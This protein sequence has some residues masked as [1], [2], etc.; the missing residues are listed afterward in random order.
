MKCCENDKKLT[1][2]LPLFTKTGT[3]PVEYT[4]NGIKYF[5]IPGNTDIRS[6]R[7]KDGTVARTV[8]TCILPGGLELRAENTEYSDFPV[9]E[10]VAFIKN[11]CAGRSAVITDFRICASLPADGDFMFCHGNGET[12][13]P[14]GYGWE[15]VPLDRGFEISPKPDGTSC[16]LA[17]PYFRLIGE[18]NG[19]NIAVGWS[20]T[21]S[22]SVEKEQ[23]QIIISASQ[24]RFRVSLEPGETVRTPLVVIQAFDG[25]ESRGRNL[26]RSFYLEHYLPRRKGRPLGPMLVLHTPG[27]CGLPEFCGTTEQNQIKGINAYLSNGLKPDIWWID[28]GW[29]PCGGDWYAGAGNWYPDPARFPKGLGSVGELAERNG[30]DLLLWFEPERVYR[31]TEIW[32]EHSDFLI[33]NTEEPDIALYYLGNKT[34]RDWITDRVDSLIKSSHVKIYRQDFNFFPADFWY[35]G[36]D[37]D[38]EGI[39]ENLH[40]QG[41]YAF[42][43]EL[44]RRNP[45]LMI[46]S[47]AGGGRRNDIETMKR[48]VPLHYTDTGYGNH[49][50]KQRQ[51]RLMF[52]WIPY[53]RAHTK[54]WDNPDG[55]YGGTDRPVDEFAYQNALTPALTSMIRWDDTEELFDLGRRFH[56]IW[57]ECAKLM[58]SGDYYPLTETN[59]SPLDWY[60]AEFY[61]Q[62]RCEGFYQVIRNIGVTEDIFTVVTELPD[63]DD[64]DM[65]EIEDPVNGAR[66]EMSAAEM[67]KGIRLSVP[68]R[69][70]EIRFFRKT[71]RQE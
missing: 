26:W 21:W 39:H 4:L 58:L 59:A 23:N 24:K 32:N 56:P 18:R 71:A 45:G 64:E 5:G 35:R 34:A 57:R 48:A 68:P 67:K 19:Y 2:C 53:F 11:T 30:I 13:S 25:D 66:E 44:L 1:G 14:E 38:R 8:I 22:F 47:C 3:I 16:L 20:G 33:F 43:D 27:I 17:F 29:Y 9:S 42:W 15:T 46:D 31:G 10:W 51:H 12:Y 52:E 63:A 41:Y 7:S 28:A 60:A 36:E 54:S 70:G 49:P 61:D 55:T 65:F 50:V 40:I 6:E 62:E 37:A 69:T